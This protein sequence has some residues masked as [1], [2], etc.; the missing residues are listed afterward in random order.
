MMIFG[1][2]D[3]P[4]IYLAYNAW[5]VDKSNRCLF[6][7]DKLCILGEYFYEPKE[8]A[9][10]VAENNEVLRGILDHLVECTGRSTF[11]LEFEDFGIR[12]EL[13]P[14]FDGMLIWA[15]REGLISMMSS[16]DLM[17]AHTEFSYARLVNPSI[18]SL[19]VAVS[20]VA[21]RML[22]GNFM[23]ATSMAKNP[24]LMK[25]VAAT[26]ATVNPLE[27]TKKGIM[28]LLEGP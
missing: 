3:V 9:M 1:I 12:P 8:H 11:V 7:H 17:N 19:G 18:T 22:D 15:L 14:F 27:D 21:I 28:G 25:A 26:Q 5:F 10:S 23:V 16:D 24:E 6:S 4:F 2:G 13:E 20:A